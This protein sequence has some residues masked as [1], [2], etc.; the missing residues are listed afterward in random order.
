LV[1]LKPVMSDPVGARPL[2][3]IGIVA[4]AAMA[5]T[6]IVFTPMSAGAASTLVAEFP[7]TTGSS[8]PQGITVGSDGNLWFTESTGGTRIG[9]ITPGTGTITE[10]SN[11]T[12]AS[13]WITS[14]PGGNLWTTESSANAI[15]EL[16]TAGARVG[17]FPVPTAFSV[18]DQI[19]LGPDGNLWFTEFAGNKIGMITPGS[20]TLPPA[21]TEFSIPSAGAGP[22]AI[23]AGSDGNLWFTEQ[24]GNRIGK[25]TTAGAIT[26]FNPVG[27]MP[28]G[29]ALGPDGNVWFTEFGGNQIGRITPAGSVTEFAVPTANSAPAS[30]TTGPDGNLWF[31]EYSGNKIG[32]MGTDG[33]MLGEFAL[34]TTPAGPNAITTGPDGSLWFT[35]PLANQ[36][37]RLTPGAAIAPTA[38]TYD[39]AT[40]GDFNDLALVSATLADSSTTPATPLAGQNVAF[41]LNGAETCSGVTDAQGHASCQLTPGETSGTYAV[42]AQFAGT[43]GLTAASTSGSFA[44]TVEETAITLTAPAVIANGSPV[45]LNAVLTED[46]KT[47]IAGR[48]VTLGLGAGAAA[49]SC[50]AT[51]NAAGAATCSIDV[52]NQALGTGA[53]LATFG[54][55]G[56]YAPASAS[57]AFVAFAFAGGGM[58]VVG[59]GSAQAGGSVTFWS[60]TWSSRNTL[61]GGPGPAS[62]KGFASTMTPVVTC[63]GTWTSTGG[64]SSNPPAGPLP[65]YMAVVVSSSVDKSGPT[66]TGNVTRIVIVKTDPSGNGTGTVVA[67]LCSA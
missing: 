52:V 23:V 57:G 50:T 22:T 59:D 24:S 33:T 26:E 15:G 54:G 21:I 4:T 41:T 16:T 29:M 8:T 36:I 58:F 64:D 66:I 47:P 63:A 48:T 56:F 5:A 51:T 55:D 17:E 1:K 38:L 43:P 53:L 46:G 20:A 60:P 11:L 61:S 37:G 25:I 49:Q 28:A 18:P 34:P 39:G 12:G 3:W 62:F 32:R 7:T 67:V 42:V 6:A 45:A 40:T 10:F 27:S 2:R 65:A 31:T 19:A 44:V 9:Q 30:I 14:V 13:F 35:E